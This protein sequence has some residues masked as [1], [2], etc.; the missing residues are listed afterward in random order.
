MCAAFARRKEGG[1]GVKPEER[2]IVALDETDLF[3]AEGYVREL[4]GVTSWFKVG[5][6]LLEQLEGSKFLQWL[7]NES[8]ARIMLDRKFYDIPSKLADAISGVAARGIEMF[9]V[10]LHPGEMPWHEREALRKAI[11]KKG[12]AMALAVGGL[13]SSR[14]VVS[15]GLAELAL[16]A[17]ADGVVASG[18]E[19]AL[20]RANPRF[21]QLL[22]AATGIRPWS[23]AGDDQVR[24]LSPRQAI[25]AGAD[26]LVIGRPILN[27][28]NGMQ[29]QD[30][31]LKIAEEV[32]SAWQETHP[33]INWSR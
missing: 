24:T 13:S 1:E 33:E 18:R 22:V 31:F 27:P 11:S 23:V 17:K 15:T 7:M 3:Q 25:L 20:L 12:E 5:P 26:Y 30:A 10:H 21:N 8:P 29:P 28:P 14:N 2:I 19:V 4:E 9:T 16:D 6:A 32:K